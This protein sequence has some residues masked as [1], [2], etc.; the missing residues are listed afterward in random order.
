MNLSFGANEHVQKRNTWRRG[1]LGGLALALGIVAVTP[2]CSV[3]VDTSTSQC[4]TDADCGAGKQCTGDKICTAVTVDPNA[5]AKTSDCTG[6]FRLCVKDAGQAT[7]TCKDIKSTECQVVDG[8]YQADNIFLFGSI[9]PTT[10]PAPDDEVGIS[11]EQSILLALNEL[12]QTTNGLPPAPGQTGNR[13]VVMIGCS[14][15]GDDATCVKVA[16]HLAELGVPAIIGGAFSSTAIKTATDVTIP[17]KMLLISASGTSPAITNLADK[18]A[19]SDVG[20]VWRT[21]PS[22]LFQA[23]AVVEY[24][25]QLETSVRTE[26]ALMPSDPIK[27]AVLHRGDA[28]GSGLKDALQSK[29]VF[30]GKPALSNNANYIV[31]N[32]GD[33]DDP[34][35]P[36][37]YGAAVDGAVNAG[38]HV[39]LLFGGGEA[40]TEVFGKIEIQWS[41]PGFRPRYVFSDANFSSAVADT[42]NS[43][44]NA[45]TR[46]DWR[47]RTTG[48]V[49][50]PADTDPLYKGFQ[51]S[52]GNRPGDPQI[53]GAA[54]AYD[55]A[56]LLF[57]SAATI[58]DGV[59]T[60]E[61]LALGMTKM[62]K[63]DPQGT[64]I[65]KV[66]SG[67][68]P[69][70]LGKL[71]SGEYKSI[72]YQGAFGPLNFD[73]ATGEPA[74][75]VQIFCLADDGMG[76]ATTQLSGEFYDADTQKLSGTITAA[77]Q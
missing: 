6:E 50:G 1:I 16:E 33:P 53:F 47:R 11:M 40:I 35:N 21:V 73:A 22:D 3:V 71:L 39:I 52:Y 38:A 69:S 7:G 36:T 75:N 20:L 77:C 12:K 42:I 37:Q 44:P 13:A 9:H 24:V 72:D 41:K 28:Y 67:D 55:A 31:V 15:A 34:V 2:S 65:V 27:V 76:K 48:V 62:S 70:A 43:E 59:F 74:A 58:A 14:D 68:L 17:K 10:A 66:G 56:Y 45:M 26:L 30:N 54:S 19:G 4:T 8:D 29:L 61:K 23:D 32:Y 57:Y 5:C 46:A 49:P 25:K 18:P 64:A 60:G 51:I 63:A